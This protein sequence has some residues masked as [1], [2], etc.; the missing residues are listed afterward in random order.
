MDSHSPV[1][2]ST[3]LASVSPGQRCVVAEIATQEPEIRS[4]LYDLGIIPGSVLKVMR[5]AP[6]GDPIQVKIG[7][8]S[9]SIRQQEA[10]HIHVNIHQ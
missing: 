9:I 2:H 8:S 7:T 1:A 5:V 10:R 3:S 6:L 4:R